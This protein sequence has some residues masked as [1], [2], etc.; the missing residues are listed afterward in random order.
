MNKTLSA[1]ERRIVGW[2]N[3]ANSVPKPEYFAGDADYENG[4]L[5]GKQ[6]RERF[7][8]GLEYH[9][10]FPIDVWRDCPWL[11]ERGTDVAP[12]RA[13]VPLDVSLGVRGPRTLPRGNTSS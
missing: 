13:D 7:C 12:G 6:A 5:A 9:E 4:F 3:G 8:A 10:E 11:H 1:K 2:G